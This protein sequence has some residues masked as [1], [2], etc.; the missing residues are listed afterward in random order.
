MASVR[1]L[2]RRAD[3]V[4][5]DR[6]ALQA[7][8]RRL[9]STAPPEGLAAT[10]D[11]DRLRH[12]AA[13][14]SDWLA[15]PE[16]AEDAAPAGALRPAL[17]I[18]SLTA[19]VLAVALATLHAWPWLVAIVP[20][21][22]AA[23]LDLRGRGRDGAERSAVARARRDDYR[24]TE[25]PEP[26]AW[27]PDAVRDRLHELLEAARS[28]DA[29]DAG[30][31]ALADLRARE[32]DVAEAEEAVARERA[33][34]RTRLGVE[35][36]ADDGAYALLIEALAAWWR[37]RAD[38]TD[39]EARLNGVEA[40][41]AEEVARARRV[42]GRYGEDDAD[43]PDVVARAVRDLGERQG[44]H[45]DAVRDRTEAQRR[46]EEAEKNL[47]HLREA[48]ADVLRRVGLED[49]EEARLDAALEVRAE[50]VKLER[51]IA[52]LEARLDERL[53]RLGGRGDLAELSEAE[54]RARSE[55]LA[56]VAARAGELQERITETRTQVRGAMEGHDLTDALQRQDVARDALV[57]ARDA[58]RDAV[59][60]AALAEAVRRETGDRARPE[61]FGRADRLLNRFTNGALRLALDDESD[62][63]AFRVRAGDGAERP[64]TALSVGE[65]IQTLVA[66]RVAFLEQDERYRLPLLLDETLGTTDDRRARTVVRAIA[67]IAREGRQVLY[68][69]A[70]RDEVAK[71]RDALDGSDVPFAAIDLEAVR[72]GDRAVRLPLPDRSD[73]PAHPE[74][75]APEEDQS[76]A[77]YGR[78]LEV[79]ALDPQHDG[80][81]DVHPYH[82]LDDVRDLH[83]V[84]A[85]GA[86]RWGQLENLVRFEGPQLLPGGERS[87]RAAQAAARALDA[88]LRLWR[89]GHGAPVD[90]SALQASGAVS[91]TFLDPVDDLA[92]ALDGDARALLEALE[93]RSVPRWRTASTEELRDHLEA[94]G[95]LPRREPPTRDE[96]RARARAAVASELREG[97]LSVAV[98]ERIVDALT[99][100]RSA[101]SLRS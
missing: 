49:G 83:A 43:D 77:A 16:V 69:T 34:L 64:I 22:V 62:P 48:R 82:L 27:T 88:A 47:V 4:A 61:T 38:A 39:A 87:H 8:R 21:V 42:L 93:D 33:D 72:R 20:A 68:F 25:L 52:D 60:G 35:L 80:V 15:R 45:D 31:R 57:S 18:A 19:A 1:E 76:Y 74:P 29:A 2:L 86:G 66:V 73:V 3:R 5:A 13:A 65:R 32:Q 9:E 50:A 89:E 12:G 75:P 46:R 58:N 36:D 56:P 94:H 67:D 51:T 37:A 23:V 91:E 81:A 98:V 30:E 44:R 40:D 78:A 28:R 63:P 70:Q 100:S 101:R 59:V 95:H 14:L 79:P 92:R 71:W 53:R 6:R 26:A 11:A 90:R 85:L 84:A 55:E 96:L 24:R 99:A 10:H 41:L 17:L 54:L 97:L 7:E